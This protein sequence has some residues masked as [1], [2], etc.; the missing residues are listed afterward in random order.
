MCLEIA[1]VLS[2]CEV[3]TFSQLQNTSAGALHR[4]QGGYNLG[5]WELGWGGKCHSFPL[6]SNWNLAF[7]LTVNVENKSI[8]AGDQ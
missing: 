7:P 5:V 1:G 8:C 3:L 6:T 4:P 2:S